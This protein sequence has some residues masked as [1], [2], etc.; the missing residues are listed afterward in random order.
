MAKRDHK[1]Q[2]LTTELQLGAAILFLWKK[3]NY[4]MRFI[5]Y[6]KIRSDL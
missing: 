2:M 6:I 3:N 5:K 1:Q 4:Q